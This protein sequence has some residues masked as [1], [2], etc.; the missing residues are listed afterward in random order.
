MRVVRKHDSLPLIMGV[1][2]VTPDSFS[3]GGIYYDKQK[4]V[5]RGLEMAEQGADIIDIG[6]EST[7][8]GSQPVELEKELER[9]VPIIEKLSSR[10]SIPISIDT[11]KKEVAEEAFKAGASIVNDISG[12]AFDKE[13][14][15]FVT[16]RKCP[17]IISHIQGTPRDMQK[18]PHYSDV[19][20]EVK[21]YFEERLQYC[22][23]IGIDKAN[24]ILDPG[25]G[26]GKRLEDNIQLISN[27]KSF[28]ALGQKL[29]VGAS[30][31][32]FIG[33]ILDEPEPRNRT[34]GSLAT[35]CWLMMEGVDILRVHDVKETKD[36]LKVFLALKQAYQNQ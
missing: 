7:R 9:V 34:A 26:F 29:L 5:D 16:E 32:S 10:V 27:I 20:G 25:I 30:R 33:A 2:N 19:I 18:N 28:K 24:V 35:Y 14:G 13:L 11:Y 15:S 6:G 12:L 1:L 8:P 4:A 17:V 21:G 22:E 36:F 23:E 31:K 3:D